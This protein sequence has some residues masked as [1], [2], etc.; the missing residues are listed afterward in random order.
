MTHG[1]HEI[2]RLYQ[3]TKNF[4]RGQLLRLETPGWRVLEFEGKTMRRENVER[5]RELI[6]RAPQVV[7]DR[8]FSFSED[9]FLDSSC[10]VDVIFPAVAKVLLWLKHC[11]WA[12]ATNWS[13]CSGLRSL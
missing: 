11:V 6:L 8:E 9:L 2:L 12:E 7:S 5:Q 1:M 3:G 13:I 10:S 4:P